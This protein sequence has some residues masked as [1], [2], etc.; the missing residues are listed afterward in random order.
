[1][2]ILVITAA[3]DMFTFTRDMEINMRTF[4]T[5]ALTEGD[6]SQVLT[7]VARILEEFAPRT[8]KTEY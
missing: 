1:V 5:I 4:I 2:N 3:G 6:E 8:R 7:S